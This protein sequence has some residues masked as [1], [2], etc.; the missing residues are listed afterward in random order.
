MSNVAFHSGERP[1]FCIKIVNVSNVDTSVLGGTA[2][3][4]QRGFVHQVFATVAYRQHRPTTILTSVRFATLYALCSEMTSE[5][6]DVPATVTA[7]TTA[8]NAPTGPPISVGKRMCLCL[9]WSIFGLLFFYLVMV[10]MSTITPNLTLD[11]IEPNGWARTASR[12]TATAT[13][14]PFTLFL[15][16]SPASI[17][18]LIFAVLTACAHFSHFIVIS[19]DINVY[20]DPSVHQRLFRTD[21][22]RHPLFNILP[23]Y[24]AAVVGTIGFFCMLIITTE[25][26]FGPS[27]RARRP[28]LPTV[29]FAAAAW[30]YAVF[31]LWFTDHLVSVLLA[32][33]NT[34]DLLHPIAFLAPLTLGM[35]VTMRRQLFLQDS[36]VDNRATTAAKKNK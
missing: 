24:T 6:T 20:K 9:F 14:A 2:D 34:P 7:V 13:V 4:V 18:S 10:F 15:L 23:L 3:Q 16:S 21:A 8:A 1:L 22:A 32:G 36:V 12:H 25:R 31:N 35:I 33:R 27:L 29:S 19:S 28:V 30:V 17:S 11:R 5:I 26:C